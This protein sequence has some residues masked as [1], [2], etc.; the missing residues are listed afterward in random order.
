MPNERDRITIAGTLY[1]QISGS[2]PT[3]ISLRCTQHILSDEQVYSRTPPKGIGPEWEALKLGW[4]EKC[5]LLCI[6]NEETSDPK[7]AGQWKEKTIMIGRGVIGEDCPGPRNKGEL[8]PFC[9]PP[10]MVSLLYPSNVI[11]L[12]IR[13]GGADSIKYTLFALP[14]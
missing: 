11:P 2:N 13:S 14:G 5:S 1:H 9:V 10:G 3:S 7:D 6:K 12:Y 8:T 4:V